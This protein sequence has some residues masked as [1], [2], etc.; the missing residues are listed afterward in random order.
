MREIKFRG[1]RID[2]GYWVVGFYAY[3]DRKHRIYPIIY[4]ITN[5]SVCQFYEVIPETVSQY[6]GLQDKNGKYIYEGDIL[7]CHEYDSSDTGKRI[8]Q[9]FKNAVVGFLNGNYYHFPKGNMK[10]PHQLLMYAYEPE[11]TGNIHDNPELLQ[12]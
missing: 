9:T 7:L 4:P 6:T 3:T 5:N 10:C 2:N 1:K 11:I 8:V 12:P